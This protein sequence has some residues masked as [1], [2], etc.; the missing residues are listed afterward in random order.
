M[1]QRAAKIAELTS[2]GGNAVSFKDASK[3]SNWAQDA[4][5]FNVENGLIVGSNGQIKPQDTITRAE[6]MVAILRLL[7]KSNLIDVKIEA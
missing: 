4:V 3:V 6:S 1:L 5:A 7:Q 2:Q